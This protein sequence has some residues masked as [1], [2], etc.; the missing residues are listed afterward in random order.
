M[1]RSVR[2]IGWRIADGRGLTLALLLAVFGPSGLAACAAA[3]GRGQTS[4]PGNAADEETRGEQRTTP[5]VSLSPQSVDP[6]G[7]TVVVIDDPGVAPARAS[8]RLEGGSPIAFFVGADSRLRALVGVDLATPPG[9]YPLVVEALSARPEGEPESVRATVTLTVRRKN[10]PREDLRV[11]RKYVEP[12][13]RTLTRI[14]REQA[15]LDAIL[16]KHVP[17]RLWSGPFLIPAD[18][19]L[20]SPFGLRRFFNGQE[21]RPHAGQDLRVPEGTPVIAA[22]AGKVVL[23]ASH[24]FSG[25]TVVLDHGLGLFTFYF[26]LASFRVMEGAAVDRSELL[27]Y[28]G[29][30]GRVTGPHLHWAA[31]LNGARVDPLIL[32]KDPAAEDTLHEREARH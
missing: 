11:A 10:F 31:R 2:K 4:G 29:K 14:W 21:R 16:A 27:G 25:N 17:Q 7:I 5:R 15:R 6:G 24:F 26:H 22:Q 1:R 28:S 9:R 8:V 23:A 12:D 19:P 13:A 32:T 18:G 20:G 3:A 30:T